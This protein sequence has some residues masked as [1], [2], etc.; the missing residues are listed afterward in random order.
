MSSKLICGGEKYELGGPKLDTIGLPVSMTNLPAIIEIEGY[1][2]SLKTEFHVSLVYIGKIAEKNK[3]GDPDIVEKIVADFC[4]FTRQ[5][6]I[7]LLR[8]RNDFRFVT[9][10]DNRSVVIM[11]DISNLDKFFNFLN[12]KY[13]LEL[14]YPPTHVTLYTLQPNIGIFLTD[15]E[16][17]SKT[18]KQID[19]PILNSK[20]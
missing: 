3:I 20:F 17:I 6:K 12:Q 16:D 7:E 4:E 11:C 15:S 19:I 9:R 14:E 8:Y 18:T 1:T 2:L 13:A 10:D 5:N